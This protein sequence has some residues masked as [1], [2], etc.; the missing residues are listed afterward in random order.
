MSQYLFGK[1]T[2]SRLHLQQWA[3]TTKV[4]DMPRHLHLGLPVNLSPVNLSHM[5]LITQW[6]RHKWAQNKAVNH[7]Y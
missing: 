1:L 4:C 7:Y 2:E 5:R 3:H 6:T